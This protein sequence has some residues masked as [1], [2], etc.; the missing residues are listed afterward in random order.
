MKKTT[1]KIHINKFVFISGLLLFCIIIGR[2]VY[3]NLSNSIDGINL[4]EFAENRNTTKEI[5]YANRGT[6][7]DKN[8]EVLAETVDS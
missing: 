7:Y 5:L 3:L 4:S 2:L 8:K 6:I 1:S